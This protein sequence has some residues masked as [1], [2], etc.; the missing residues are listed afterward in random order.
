MLF[1]VFV[2]AGGRL[3][4]GSPGRSYEVQFH[5]IKLHGKLPYQRIK[6]IGIN[7]ILYRV[8]WDDEEKGGLYFINTRFRT[9]EPA[10]EKLIEEFD[11]KNLHLCAWMI[12]RKFAWI[13]NT[14][15]FDYR[16]ENN[17]REVVRKMD[18]FNPDAVKRIVGAYK[19]LASHRIASIL[20]QDDLVLRYNEGFSN[21]GKA[22]FTSLTD[23]PARESLMMKKNTPYHSTWKRVKIDQVNELVNRIVKNCKSVNSAVTVGM[24]IYYETPVHTL[25]AE[26]WY[27]HNLRGLAGTGLDYIYLMAYHRQIKNEMKWNEAKNREFFKTMVDR[28]YAVCKEKLVVKLQIKDWKTGDRIPAEEIA[29]YMELIPDGVQRVC[30]TPAGFDDWDYLESLVRADKRKR[31]GKRLRR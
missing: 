7:K 16:F 17:R 9:L 31:S 12:S 23:V 6:S 19:E 29:A 28:A 10:L 27:S 2:L 8:F 5:T 30:F 22:R 18:I 14:R 13:T 3:N 21:W 11:H 26:E 20:I 25:R 24:N 4:G 15:L 1:L